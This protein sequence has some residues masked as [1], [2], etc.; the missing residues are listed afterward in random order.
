MHIHLVRFQLL[1]RTKFDT[2]APNFAPSV[3]DE[4][5]WKDT[6]LAPPGHTTFVI[7]RFDRPGPYVVHCHILEHEDHDMMRPY[8]IV[9]RQ[10]C[11]KKY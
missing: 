1:R 8:I 3:A 4:F 7:A 9:G 2:T 10:Q 11:S 6:I 5:G